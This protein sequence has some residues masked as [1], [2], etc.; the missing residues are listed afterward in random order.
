MSTTS[1]VGKGGLIAPRSAAYQMIHLMNMQHSTGKS[2]IFAF[3][4]F[5]RVGRAAVG[6]GECGRAC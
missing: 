1:F 6:V 4:V 5:G 2:R 3:V